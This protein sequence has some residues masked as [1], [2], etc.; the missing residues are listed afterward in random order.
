MEYPVMGIP[1]ITIRDNTERPETVE[2][3]TNILVGKDPEKL[4]KCLKD[5]FEN[6]WK[7]G[8]I[9][10]LWDG[11]TANRIV[12]KILSIQGY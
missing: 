5:V 12:N 7:K 4:I 2:T 1:C 10:E 3:G 8:E 9:P 6:K 11:N